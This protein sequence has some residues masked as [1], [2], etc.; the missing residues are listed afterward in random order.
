[1]TTLGLD[2]YQDRCAHGYHTTQHPTFCACTEMSEWVIFRLALSQAAKDGKVHQADVRPLI[3]GRIEPKHIGTLYRRARTEGLLV[4]V[5]HERSDDV[6][7][8]NAGR[9]EPVYLWHGAAA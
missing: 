7:G 9:L 5:T 3:R 8:K 1:M 6:V 4:E 2:V